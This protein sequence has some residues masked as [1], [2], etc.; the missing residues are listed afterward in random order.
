MRVIILLAVLVPIAIIVGL[1]VAFFVRGSRAAR[2]LEARAAAGDTS[3]R[4]ELDKRRR[5][6]DALRNAVDDPERKRLMAVGIPA[7]A[8]VLDVKL[9]GMRMAVDSAMPKRMT[10]VTL[11]LEGTGDAPAP[12]ILVDMVPEP[13]LARLLKGATLPVRVDPDDPQKVAIVW[14]TL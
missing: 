13:Y 7:R 10:E 1:I 14:D 3:A 6:R 8:G 9:L 5:V 12:I 11:A 4:A 2:E